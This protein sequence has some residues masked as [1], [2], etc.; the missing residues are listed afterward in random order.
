MFWQANVVKC[1]SCGG[2]DFVEDERSGDMICTNDGVVARQLTMCDNQ[3]EYRLF[4][5]DPGSYQRQRLGPSQNIMMGSGG[6]IS[7][8][9]AIS[10][11]ALSKGVVG[12][13]GGGGGG[14]L[15]HHKTFPY[16]AQQFL[17]EA[18]RNI[19]EIFSKLYGDSNSNKEA[20]NRAK[21]LF[22]L[23]HKHQLDKKTKGERK[24]FSRR[25]Q[26]VVTCVYRALWV[27]NNR[28]TT[29]EKT[30]FEL[31][32]TPSHI[33]GLIQGTYVSAESV[34]RCLKEL[35]AYMRDYDVLSK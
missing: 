25:K 29:S 33:S 2:D 30:Q 26:F 35:D 9:T 32:W 27:Q 4:R 17:D 8:R 13:G 10:R 6:G 15:R 20:R 14:L 1:N 24:K 19:D 23:V 5:D 21:Y 3:P 28:E 12:V 18:I 34:K 16:D 11:T 7:L 22:S 31:A